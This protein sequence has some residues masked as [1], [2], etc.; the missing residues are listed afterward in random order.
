MHVMEVLNNAVETSA[1]AV[2]APPIPAAVVRRTAESVDE[3][4][5]G[6]F[7]PPDREAVVSGVERML[8]ERAP[9]RLET[10]LRLVER[11]LRPRHWSRYFDELP[12]R[13][14][15]VLVE[16]GLRSSPHDAGRPHLGDLPLRHLVLSSSALPLA[17]RHVGTHWPRTW[18]EVAHRLDGRPDP[19]PPPENRAERVR[20]LNR[21][22]MTPDEVRRFARPA[23]GTEPG[24]AGRLPPVDRQVDQIVYQYRLRRD[25]ECDA[26]VRAAKLPDAAHR[27]LIERLRLC[28][29]RMVEASREFSQR[30]QSVF[31][32]WDVEWHVSL[33][34]HVFGDGCAALVKNTFDQL[35]PYLFG[36]GLGKERR[37]ICREHARI[38]DLLEG[39]QSIKAVQEFLSHTEVVGRGEVEP[40]FRT[41]YGLQIRGGNR[42]RKLVDDARENYRSARGEAMERLTAEVD[43]MGLGDVYIYWSDRILPF[44]ACGAEGKAVHTAAVQRADRAGMVS[45][46]L[47]EDGPAGRKI[48]GQIREWAAEWGLRHV[49]C[50]HFRRTASGG[51]RDTSVLEPDGTQALFLRSGETPVMSVR[52]PADDRIQWD[53]GEQTRLADWMAF[54][55]E[56]LTHADALHLLPGGIREAITARATGPIPDDDREWSAVI[57]HENPTTEPDHAAPVTV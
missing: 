19:G 46:Y 43:R 37:A 22:L 47:L 36:R 24:A 51:E 29:Q 49:H 16:C 3:P 33:V 5:W 53:R 26:L 48:A 55:D 57:P 11:T 52:D 13:Q 10:H 41:E 12:W 17:Y 28:E 50:F 31:N 7:S 54:L 25:L 14:H 15:E 30:D 32:T 56:T 42:F 4:D 18:R 21:V 6:G 40:D 44:E 38:R 45:V 1:A 35:H 27:A 8:V 2:P 20:R 39:K 9:D 23:D 34:R